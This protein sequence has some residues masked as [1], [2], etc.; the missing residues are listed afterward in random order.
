[1]LR[2]ISGSELFFKV[3]L[4]AGLLTESDQNKNAL[5]G[6]LFFFSDA[7]ALPASENLQHLH[8]IKY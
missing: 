3:Q 6:T 7:V 2:S 5:L 4:T 1:M 8:I